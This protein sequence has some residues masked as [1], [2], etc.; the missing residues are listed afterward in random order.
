M[1]KKE[2]LDYHVQRFVTHVQDLAG[3]FNNRARKIGLPIQMDTRRLVH[4][5][6]SGAILDETAN[7]WCNPLGV[8]QPNDVAVI[9]DC[10]FELWKNERIDGHLSTP[11]GPV[12][13][14]VIT[15]LQWAGPILYLLTGRRYHSSFIVRRNPFLYKTFS[16]VLSLF[17][18]MYRN[19]DFLV[20]EG[21][22]GLP[23][24]I[25]T[26]FKNWPSTDTYQRFVLE[27]REFVFQISDLGELFDEGT[28]SVQGVRQIKGVN[29]QIRGNGST[30]LFIVP[31]FARS[32]HESAAPSLEVIQGMRN[33]FSWLRTEFRGC[34]NQRII[35]LSSAT[36]EY[37]DLDSTWE[38]SL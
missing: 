36:L 34:Q 31:H 26:I 37:E 17:Q 8:L 25:N 7:F 12:R 27:A 11:G 13:V 24:S 33:I 10:C 29:D 15:A 2:D 23:S 30:P 28:A 38:V 9:A 19:I 21:T 20:D 32:Q 14:P 18:G 16:K 5:V 1:N 6:H 22:K 35:G 4:L 3:K